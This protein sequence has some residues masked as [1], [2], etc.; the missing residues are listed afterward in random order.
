M[1]DVLVAL[2]DILY[3]RELLEIQ[4]SIYSTIVMVIPSV[5]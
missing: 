3:I 2:P 1:R 4:Q 5:S